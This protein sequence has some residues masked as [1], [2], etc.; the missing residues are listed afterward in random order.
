MYVERFVKLFCSH[1]WQNLDTL[2]GL[3]VQ[4]LGFVAGSARGDHSSC[5]H[6]YWVSMLVAHKGLW[7]LFCFQDFFS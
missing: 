1:K 5:T 6:C 2:L 3:K 4:V 7:L